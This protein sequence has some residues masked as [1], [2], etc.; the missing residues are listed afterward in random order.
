MTV[1]AMLIPAGQL[2]IQW[3]AQSKWCWAATA[4]S[5]VNHFGKGDNQGALATSLLGFDAKDVR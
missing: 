4:A 3:Q 5:I 2:T 1:T